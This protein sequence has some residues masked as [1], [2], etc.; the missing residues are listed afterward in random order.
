MVE[1]FSV[2]EDEV[3]ALEVLAREVV[4]DGRPGVAGVTHVL[5]RGHRRIG[6]QGVFLLKKK[7]YY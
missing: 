6:S 4:G 2:E 3:L 7:V 5:K 1:T